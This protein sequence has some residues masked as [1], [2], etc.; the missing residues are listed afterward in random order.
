MREQPNSQRALLE[1]HCKSIALGSMFYPCTLSHNETGVCIPRDQC[2]NEKKAIIV[3]G[4][5]HICCA[6]STAH[7]CGYQKT[8]LKSRIIGGRNAVLGEFPWM[9]RLIHKD[10][11]GSKMFG[12]AGFLIS[13][14]ILL[15]AGHCLKSENI[16]I[17]GPM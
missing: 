6:L 14:D 4:C 8:V 1:I 17:L 2:L 15:T 11:D 7:K 12:C 3:E 10:S 5:K 9:A 13:S 16:A